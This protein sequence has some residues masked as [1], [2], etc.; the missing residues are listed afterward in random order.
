M[1]SRGKTQVFGV[2]VVFFLGVYALAVFLIIGL[3]IFIWGVL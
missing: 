3:P 2:D 1:P